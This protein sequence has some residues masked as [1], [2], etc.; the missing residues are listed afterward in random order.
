MS[1]TPIETTVSSKS[2]QT[3]PQASETTERGTTK[4]RVTKR[5]AVTATAL[6]IIMSTFMSS[7][8]AS[9]YGLL[10][11]NYWPWWNCQITAGAVFDTAG[12][13]GHFAVIGGGQ[14]RNCATRHTFHVYVQEQLSQNGTVY[15][16]GAQSVSGT[17]ANSYGMSATQIQTTARLCGYNGYYRTAVRVL[18]DGYWS[19]WVYSSWTGPV[20]GYC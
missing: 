18:A 14:L 4:R 19:N 15:N 16:L 12:S 5:L 13:N 6:A 2:E 11:Y 8:S 17:W 10:G 9:S 7:A 1:V 3:S 20:T